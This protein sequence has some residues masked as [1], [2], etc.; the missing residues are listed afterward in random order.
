[1]QNSEWITCSTDWAALFPLARLLHQMHGVGMAVVLPNSNPGR[2]EWIGIAT[3][4][5]SRGV[6]DVCGHLFFERGCS[7]GACPSWI[8]AAGVCDAVSS[9][10]F[11]C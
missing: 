5:E 9:F 2:T 1:M 11:G 8:G 3:M 10:S 6:H 7:A 4:C